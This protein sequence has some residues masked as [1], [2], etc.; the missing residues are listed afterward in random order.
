MEPFQISKLVSEILLLIFL[1]LDLNQLVVCRRVNKHLL[2]VIDNN[3]LLWKIFEWIQQDQESFKP[4]L[5]M[6][7]EKSQ[8][9][10]R[11]VLI[12]DQHSKKEDLLHLMQVLEKS[13]K[14]LEEVTIKVSRY[15]EIHHQV[16]EK[17]TTSS[18]LRSLVL[19]EWKF[20]WYR[21][22]F[23]LAR[24][25]PSTSQVKKSPVPHQLQLL[26]I[27]DGIAK[28]DS[29]HLKSFIS[30]ALCRSLSSQKGLELIG[31][32]SESL[33]HLRISFNDNYID[34]GSSPV[35]LFC[36]NLICL[37]GWFSSGVSSFFHAPRL[38]ILVLEV[39]AEPGDLGVVPPLVEEIWLRSRYVSLNEVEDWN[40]LLRLC[41]RLKVLKLMEGFVFYPSNEPLIFTG[42]IE[43]LETRSKMVRDEKEIDGIK[44]MPLQKLVLP[45]KSFNKEELDRAAKVVEVI[46]VQDYPDF[47]EIE[48]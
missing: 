10:L 1:H 7:N 3:Q 47:I 12:Q 27:V 2:E 14:S 21:I 37:E 36:P 23:P 38:R 25:V 33:M 6:F 31:N 4:A 41:P 29:K 20:E 34:N 9:S 45:T 24:L 11:K 19:W 22:R 28:M 32:F 30:F 17:L 44:I 39:V 18:S 5:D 16:L 8:S 40:P 15:E 42:I 35:P 46:D 13:K 48:Y 43:M 26:W